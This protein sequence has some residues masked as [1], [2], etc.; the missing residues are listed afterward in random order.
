MHSDDTL[1]LV[2][3]L[4][5][6]EQ[7]VRT[8]HQNVWGLSIEKLFYR[9]VLDLCNWEMSYITFPQMWL[10]KPNQK[11]Q[12]SKTTDYWTMSHKYEAWLIN[13]K[14]HMASEKLAIQFTS[15]I[16]CLHIEQINFKKPHSCRMQMKSFILWV[17]IRICLWNWWFFL[18]LSV[19]FT[20]VFAT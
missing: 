2:S 15:D 7:H 18:L 20:V 3:V 16:L 6:N 19:L 8:P 5:K 4:V 12:R 10:T 14:L 13:A 11:R 1:A 9:A 17:K